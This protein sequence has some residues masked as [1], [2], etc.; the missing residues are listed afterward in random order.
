VSDYRYEYEWDGSYCYPNSPVL[1]N[2]LGIT[3]GE[4]LHETERAATAL[5]ISSIMDSPVKGR[6]DLAHLMAIHKAI[7]SGIF[8]WAG[9]LRTVNIAKGNPFCQSAYLVDYATELFDKLKR[10]GFLAGATA[11]ELPMRL[12]YYL[13]EI[14]VLHPFREGNGRTQRVFIDYLARYNGYHL[15]FS[16]VGDTEMIEVSAQA[17]DMHYGKLEA[18]VRRII[19]AIPNDERDMFRKA[20]KSR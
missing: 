12:A 15:D 16:D 4:L 8:G 3:D 13:S 5:L 11:E 18:L 14:N 7:F 9:K 10:E 20:V 6:F 1:K 19:V 2:K 17:F